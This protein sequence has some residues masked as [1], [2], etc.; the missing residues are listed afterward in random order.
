MAAEAA[1]RT[2]VTDDPAWAAST[3]LAAGLLGD[4]V[5]LRAYQE[6]G[7]VLTLPPDV[8]ADPEIR[9]R[10]GPWFGCSPYPPDRPGRTALLDALDRTPPSPSRPLEGALS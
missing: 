8:F 10:I 1:G 4:P 3:A 7:C 9:A 5:L 2:Y 6:I